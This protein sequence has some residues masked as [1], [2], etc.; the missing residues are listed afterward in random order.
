MSEFKPTPAQERAI[1]TIDRSVCVRAGAGTGKTSVLV[2]RYMELLRTS[3]ASVGDIAAL[4]YTEKAAKV[5][6][7][8][9]RQECLREEENARAEDL[10]VVRRMGAIPVHLG[11]P[12]ALFRRTVPTARVLAALA[13]RI[14]ELS[15]HYP[16]YRF[17]I[18]RGRLSRR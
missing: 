2:G 16:T 13:E 5:M 1:R 3:R 6:K 11:M 8:R 4:T 14:P 9:I 12:E 18:A 10:D 7:D 17:D 15:H